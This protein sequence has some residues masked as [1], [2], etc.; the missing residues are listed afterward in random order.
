MKSGFRT[1]VV[2]ALGVLVGVGHVA[3]A[4]DSGAQHNVMLI[5]DASGSMKKQVEGESRMVAAKRVLAQTLATIPANVRLGLLTYGHRKAKDCTDLELVSPIG[6]ED[7]LT[8]ADRIQKLTPKG[9]TPIAA[10]LEMA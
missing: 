6:A 5:V 3:T 9:E 10:S 7:A 8:I 1:G 4:Q 2:L